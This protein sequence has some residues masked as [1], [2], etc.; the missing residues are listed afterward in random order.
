MCVNV[1]L[2]KIGKTVDLA[3]LIL[4]YFTFIVCVNTHIF[5]IAKTILACLNNCISKNIRI[6]N[7]FSKG[8]EDMI[9]SFYTSRKK[10]IILWILLLLLVF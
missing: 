5:K 3:I 8:F 9:Q 6:Y 10:F 2:L 4:I 1:Y 7:L